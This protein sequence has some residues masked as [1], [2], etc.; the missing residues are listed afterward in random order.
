MA[1]QS[2]TSK[3]YDRQQRAQRDPVSNLIVA[4]LRK[5]LS[6]GS[7]RFR[8]RVQQIVADEQRKKDQA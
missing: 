5:W 2:R 4:F 3:R 8:D 1:E 6:P 7:L